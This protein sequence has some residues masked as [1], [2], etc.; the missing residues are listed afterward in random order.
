[1][2]LGERGETVMDSTFHRTWTSNHAGTVALA[3]SSLDAMELLLLD[4]FHHIRV[5]DASVME[6]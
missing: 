6:P 2:P 1:M 3:G 4:D 5:M